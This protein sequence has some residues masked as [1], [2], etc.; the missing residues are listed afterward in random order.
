MHSIAVSSGDGIGPEIMKVTLRVLRESGADLQIHEVE[1]GERVY[2]KGFTTGIEPHTWEILKNASCFLKAPITTPQGGGFKSLNVTIRNALGL[3]AN[4]RPSISYFPFIA[5]LHPHMNVMIIRENEEDLYIGTEYRQTPHVAVA[6]KLISREGCERIHRYAFEYARRWGHKK[7]SCFSK[8][9]I[10]K[11]SDGL[12]HTIYNEVGQEYPDLEKEHWIID[13]GAAKLADSPTNF[14]VI[15]LP[16]LYGDIL[17]DIAAQISGSVGLAPSANI[18]DNSAMFEAVHGSAPRLAGKNIANPS[19]LLLSSVMMM[20]YLGEGEVSRRIRD[21]WSCTI[22]QGFHTKDIFDQKISQ[23]LVGTKEFGEAVIK[24]L[25]NQPQTLSCF[26]PKKHHK[27][28]SSKVCYRK[29]VERSLVGVDLFIY[30]K[31]N[32]LTFHQELSK[33]NPS[34][35][36]LQ[37]IFNR[38]VQIWPEGHTETFCIEQMQCRFILE[39]LPVP[40]IEIV[41]L[42]YRLVKSGFDLIKSE[43]LY[44]IDGVLGYSS[45]E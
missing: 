2:L 8:D 44:K 14:D 20:E 27:I 25:G 16:N 18:G 23:Y 38:G 34:P 28:I 33:V 37:A 42:I 1:I 45:S 43:N 13:I 19:A 21:A 29:E 26:C 41:E 17:S 39:T 36:Y 5:T 31:E 40:P 4:L 35:F 9:N 15:V 10:L 7:V 11:L 32:P 22:E 30:T 12:F 24:N 6:H 3:Y